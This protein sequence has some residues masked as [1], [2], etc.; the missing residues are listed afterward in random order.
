MALRACSRRWADKNALGG[1][2]LHRYCRLARLL[3]GKP[4][5]RSGEARILYISQINNL[6]KPFQQYGTRARE[7]GRESAWH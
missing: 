1:L 2:F 4:W 6:F 7:R 3:F 5:N